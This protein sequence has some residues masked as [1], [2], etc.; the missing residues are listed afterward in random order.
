MIC[1]LPPIDTSLRRRRDVSSDNQQMPGQYSLGFQ[2]GQSDYYNN[3]SAVM[4]G[5]SG[6]FVVYKDPYLHQFDTAREYSWQSALDIILQV[7]LGQSCLCIL[8]QRLHIN[9]SCTLFHP[10]IVR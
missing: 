6:E 7:R 5:S 10:N 1:V 3:V 8:F 4:P 2:L 9:Y